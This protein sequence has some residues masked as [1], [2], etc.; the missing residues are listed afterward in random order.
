VQS[1]AAM[2]FPE[3][4]VL[5]SLEVMVSPMLTVPTPLQA[6]PVSLVHL[7]PLLIVRLLV[8][9]AATLLLRDTLL[10]LDTL[11]LTDTLL[12]STAV[13]LRTVHPLTAV[14]HHTARLPCPMARLQFPMARLQL[15]M[16]RHHL[17][18]VL[19]TAPRLPSLTV[20]TQV[21]PLHLT[22]PLTE[23]AT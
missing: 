5:P 16:A 19:L 1:L 13:L 12:S 18:T 3:P 22:A 9:T 20:H 23:T 17:P 21:H 8:L 6:S 15:P 7:L 10:L 2:V 11:L 14:L 4:M